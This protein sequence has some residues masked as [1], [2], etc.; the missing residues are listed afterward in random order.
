[1]KKQSLYRE[2]PAC[3]DCIHSREIPCYDHLLCKINGLVSKDYCCRHFSLHI[4]SK[5]SLRSH[6]Y[7]TNKKAMDSLMAA[8]L[9]FEK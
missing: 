2:I 5:K 1:M 7:T 3:V 9:S 6:V 8:I 4:N